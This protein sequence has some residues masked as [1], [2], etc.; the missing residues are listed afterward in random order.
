[1]AGSSLGWP[2][3]GSKLDDKFLICFFGGPLLSYFPA[4]MG[5][6]SGGAW[7]GLVPEN[8]ISQLKVLFRPAVTRA[9]LAK[10]GK[11]VMCYCCIAPV[12]LL[13]LFSGDE[14]AFPVADICCYLLPVVRGIQW[15]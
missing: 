2:N 8:N 9:G 14:E 11:M 13:R 4:M 6:F 12:R 1:M 10:A 3:G 7:P 15:I 5:L